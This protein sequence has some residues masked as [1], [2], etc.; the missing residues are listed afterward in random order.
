MDHDHR[1]FKDELYAEYARV[2][3]M[4]ASPKR[5]ELLDLLAQRA[6]SV[7]ELASEAGLTLANTSRHLRALATAK[8]VESRRH[9]I[10]VEYAIASLEVV[11]LCR[12]LQTLAADRLP[13]V[14]ALNVRHRGPAASENVAEE[15]ALA[16]VNKRA[17]LVVDVRPEGEFRAGHIPGARSIPIAELVKRGA[18]S[19]LPRERAIVVYCRGAACVWA[20][21]AV[22]LLRK[23][24]FRASRLA[25][26]AP[27]FALAGGELDVAG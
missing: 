6:W 11:R 9:G 20:D 19:A 15:R 17:A 12:S 10:Y 4:L 18:T 2:G 7:E 13:D 1:R 23:R 16:I 22:H 8:L 27:G 24:G 3:A 26:D 25:L 5:L 14:R 21:E